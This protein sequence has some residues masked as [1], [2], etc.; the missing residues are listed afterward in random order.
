VSNATAERETSNGTG[1][2]TRSHDNNAR[3][4]PDF[5]VSKVKVVWEYNVRNQ[6]K[7]LDPDSKD[8]VELAD[9]IAAHGL[10]Q[11][12]VVQE[13]VHPPK[14]GK[15]GSVEYILA[16]GF[17]RFTA[18]S[19]RLGWKKV[20]VK[21]IDG[22]DYELKMANLRENI[23]R[24]DV[25]PYEVAVRCVEIKKEYGKSGKQIGEEV[26]FSKSYVNNLIRIVEK[27][28]PK[29]LTAFKHN[30][31]HESIQRYYQL[32]GM[33]PDD[34]VQ[35]LEEWKNEESEE[36]AAQAASDG[37]KKKK[38]QKKLAEGEKP[39]PK[40]L[41]AEKTDAFI[42]DLGRAEEIKLPGQGWVV[43]NDA[44]RPYLMAVAKFIRGINTTYPLRSPKAEAEKAKKEAEKA[45]KEKGE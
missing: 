10:L 43:I 24:K 11:N 23:G 2:K 40:M 5:D 17:R 19:K 12:I 33:S 44:D 16:A 32:A 37:K 34:Q 1:S 35:A 4:I 28:H 39:P 45:K 13:R 8:I 18:V 27:L 9:D 25:R 38:R 14:D 3:I 20:P 36:E 26:G 31:S 15:P 7:P 6:G 30:D 29:V 42:V 21:C 41:R 22:G